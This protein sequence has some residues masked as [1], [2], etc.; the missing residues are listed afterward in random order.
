MAAP[1]FGR[2]STVSFPTPF[3]SSVGA[4][5]LPRTRDLTWSRSACVVA[6]AAALPASA[7]I[8]SSSCIEKKRGSREPPGFLYVASGT[9][10]R[11]G[12]FDD[13]AEGRLVEHREIGE[14]LAV[15]VDPRFLQ[16][17][18]ELAV[19]HARFAGAGV[20]ARDP[21][22]AKLALPVAPVAIR[23]LPRLHHRLLGDLVYVLA[24]AAVPVGLVED[25]LVARARRDSAFYA[26][27]GGS[28]GVGKHRLHVVQVGLVD[29]RAAAKVAL[30]LGGSLGED[31][32]LARLVAL[33]RAAAAD[34]K[35]LGGATLGL[36]LGHG[37]PPCIWC[38][39]W[40]NRSALFDL[41]SP[42]LVTP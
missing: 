15:H 2:S 20:D 7:M 4:P 9:E 24:P 41:Q 5:A 18:H 29:R 1:A 34:P 12:L 3:S 21:E 37:C 26:W 38:S 42:S 16:P 31:M 23:I 17:R 32:A 14:D 27:H 11:F 13:A 25:L 30:V 22:R 36:H 6:P 35:A 33:D 10:A 19:R 8:F 40:R 39:R 28:L